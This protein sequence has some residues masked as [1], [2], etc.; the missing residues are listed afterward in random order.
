MCLTKKL[1]IRLADAL[2]TTFTSKISISVCTRH[3][4]VRKQTNMAQNIFALSAI[5]KITLFW[6]IL[7]AYASL[8]TSTILQTVLRSVETESPIRTLQNVM[9]VISCLVMVAQVTV[10]LRKIIHVQVF[11]SSVF[12]IVF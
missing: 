4:L 8:A 5:L 11:K 2:I 6:S 9:M 1:I 10:L 3:T 12:H 7:N